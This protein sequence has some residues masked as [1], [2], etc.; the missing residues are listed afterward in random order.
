M[1]EPRRAAL[2]F[3]RAASLDP[4]KPRSAPATWASSSPRRSSGGGRAGFR[5]DGGAR[6]REQRGSLSAG[7]RTVS[8]DR[9]RARRPAGSDL[10][11]WPLVGSTR[12][13]KSFLLH[14]LEHDSPDPSGIQDEVR[15]GPF[16]AALKAQL[17]A[18]TREDVTRDRRK[19]DL[20]PRADLQTQCALAK[21]DLVANPQQVLGGI[22]R[23]RRAR[24][25][26]RSARSAPSARAPGDLAPV[27]RGAGP[28]PQNPRAGPRARSTAVRPRRPRSDRCSGVGGH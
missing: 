24:G 7:S 8:A 27:P 12:R 23:Q 19:L 28:S 26:R 15:R 14:A 5:E 20:G 11:T 16:V 3:E 1:G 17:R 25:P 2:D 10:C 13:S 6:A 21:R 9:A 22:G 4:K 18:A